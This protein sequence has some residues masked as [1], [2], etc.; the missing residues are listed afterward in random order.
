M[1]WS[2]KVSTVTITKIILFVSR[3]PGEGDNLQ[4]QCR[5][6]PQ[7]WHCS[8]PQTQNKTLTLLLTTFGDLGL[9][10][11]DL[12]IRHSDPWWPCTTSPRCCCSAPM[13]WRPT[14]AP[15]P[16]WP[17]GPTWRRQ[18]QIS[19]GKVTSWSSIRW[20]EGWI[21]DRVVEGLLNSFWCYWTVW[22]YRTVSGK[23][24]YFR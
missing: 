10:A 3:T 18:S 24:N 8:T 19:G 17:G 20:R 21:W 12:Y 9:G 11:G 13:M 23:C 15:S 4:P 16:R 6:Q 22:C 1:G 2:L 5:C 7:S 14:P